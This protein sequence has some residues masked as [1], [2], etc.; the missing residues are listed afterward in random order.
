MKT[1]LYPLVNSVRVRRQTPFRQ[2]CEAILSERFPE[3]VPLPRIVRDASIVNACT[4]DQ[5]CEFI[6]EAAVVFTTRLHAGILAALLG[7]PTVIFGGPYHKIR[8]IYDY[9]LADRP[10]VQFEG[11]SSLA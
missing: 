9:S 7:R 2:R 5:F 4:F 1:A 6:S 3:A 10:H 8:G 11:G